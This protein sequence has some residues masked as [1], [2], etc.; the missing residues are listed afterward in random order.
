LVSRKLYS[1]LGIACGFILIDYGFNFLAVGLPGARELTSQFVGASLA[2]G[3][4]AA[5]FV[6]LFSLLSANP[7]AQTSTSE[8][9][10]D[11]GVETVVV[12]ETGPQYAFYKHIE[13]IG[14]FFTA[15]GL[16]SAAD[17][18][19]Q[20]FIYQL[21]DETRWWIEILLVTF[22]VLSYAIFGSIGRIGS[23][24]ERQLEAELHQPT[25]LAPKAETP[26]APQLDPTLQVNVADFI[27]SPSG[28]YERHRVDN[29]YD[30][31][32]I[33]PDMV[34]IWRED[35]QAIRAVYLAGP[36]E[37]TRDHLRQEL[38]RGEEVKVGSLQLSPQ[39][40]QDLLKLQEKPVPA[41]H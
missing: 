36:Y 23:Q 27:R 12:E 35:R 33:Q 9:F 7:P 38:G 3:G 4:S 1:I 19:L 21:Y 29:V 25:A 34:T 18:I 22:G 17:L 16:I 32:R 20:V 13:Y 37:L 6:S 31:I 5:V 39:A 26:P 24:E 10:V 41:A 40:V 14:Y 15:L 28:D 30:M 2:V 11:V 8:A